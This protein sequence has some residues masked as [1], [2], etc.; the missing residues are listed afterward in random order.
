M[1]LQFKSPLNILKIPELSTT[2]TSSTHQARQDIGTRL[3]ALCMLQMKASVKEIK[4][5]TGISA[6]S[7]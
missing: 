1:H 2:T 7:I 5:I 6:Q 3:Q 4:E